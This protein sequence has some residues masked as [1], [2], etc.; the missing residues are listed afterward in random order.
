MKELVDV[1]HSALKRGVVRGVFDGTIEEVW[2]VVADFD[3]QAEFMPRM[4]VSKVRERKENHVFQYAALDMP[5]PIADVS[6]VVDI[7]V[8]EHRRQLAFVM[9]PNSGKGVRNFNG[10]TKLEPFPRDPKKTL[11]TLTIFFEPERWY[12][13]WIINLGTKSTLGK[14]VDAVRRRLRQQQGSK[15]DLK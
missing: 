11:G 10:S 12:P 7:E 4:T 1:P 13:K 8:Q 6:Y 2:Q 14:V 15:H 5:W 9:V 3:R